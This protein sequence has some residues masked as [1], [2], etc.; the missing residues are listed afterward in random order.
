MELPLEYSDHF[1]F[2]PCQ[3]FH[4]SASYSQI[5][6]YQLIS[7]METIQKCIFNGTQLQPILMHYLR[8]T[9]NLQ[10][11]RTLVKIWDSIFQCSIYKL[12]Y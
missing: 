2:V 7:Y 1:S 10:K 8:F 12:M 11:P 3:V 9:Y 6:L 4:L 5:H